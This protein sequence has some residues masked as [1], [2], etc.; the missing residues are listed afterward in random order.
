MGKGD[1]KGDGSKKRGPRQFTR[2]WVKPSLG[3]SKERSGFSPTELPPT[4]EEGFLLVVRGEESRE[5]GPSAQHVG[6][7]L[8]H[9]M[10]T[11]QAPLVQQMLACR[12]TLRGH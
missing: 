10:S 7:A 8:G 3:M 2:I 6:R 11:E 1:S 12:C 9:G 5:E 4:G